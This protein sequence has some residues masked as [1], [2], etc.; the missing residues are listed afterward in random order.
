MI[1]KHPSL[2]I[3][4]KIRG[5]I[6]SVAHDNQ[7]KV[8]LNTAIFWKCLEI[9]SGDRFYILSSIYLSPFGRSCY[10]FSSRSIQWKRDHNIYL[11]GKLSTRWFNKTLY[12]LWNI[13]YENAMSRLSRSIAFFSLTTILYGSIQKRISKY[14]SI[15]RLINLSNLNNIQWILKA[16]YLEVALCL[17]AQTVQEKCLSILLLS[18]WII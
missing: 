8:V 13:N 12:W 18:L 5:S 1:Q 7:G 15:L 9:G 4:L 6:N 14:T 3:P 17:Q 2:L 10:W 11:F 16:I